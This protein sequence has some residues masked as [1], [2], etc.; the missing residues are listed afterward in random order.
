LTLEIALV[1]ALLV[2]SLVLYSLER[3]PPDVTALGLL[4]ALVLLGLLPASKAFAGFG[5]DTVIM[6]LSLLIMTAALLR[7]G[8][9][10][11]VG[12]ALLRRTGTRPETLLA[13]IMVVVALLS[14]FISNTAAAAF[15]IPVTIGVAQKAGIPQ[16]KLLMPLAFAAILTSS[17]S[18]IS[19]STNLVVNGLMTSRG[20]APMGMFE[21]APVGIPIAIVGLLYVYFIGRRLVPDRGSP[22]ELIE[23]FG[24][25]S[26]LSEVVLLESSPMVGKTIAEAG[27]GHDLDLEILRIR[28][29]KSL[30]LAPRAGTRLLAGDELIVE[31]PREELLKVKDVAGIE[32]KADI[33]LSDPSLRGEEVS[34]VEALLVPGSGLIG[35]TLRGLQF[36]ERYG[37]QVLGLNRHGKNVLRRLSRIKLRVGDV[38]LV[39]GDKGRI[40]LLADQREISVLG[41]VDGQ[42]ID[43]PRALRA[44]IVFGVTLLLASCNVLPLPVAGLLGAFAMFVLRCATP[45]DSYRDVEWRVVI[46]IACMLGFGEAMASTGTAK[47]LA[48]LAADAT[49][50]LAPTWLLGGFFLLTVILTQPMS[51]QAAA[52]VIVPIALEMAAHLGLDPRPFAMMIAVAASCSYLT[53]L[54]PACLLVYGPGRYRFA[55]FFRVGGPLVVLLFLVAL[56]LVPWLWPP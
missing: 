48:Q 2:A 56:L 50:G 18:L 52:A 35:H 1:L 30:E 34:L 27:L 55:D 13:V 17:V 5:S 36:R 31:G 51:N 26:Y 14:A 49:A 38:L 41:A 45:E 32:I 19:T 12:R 24:M 33:E 9:V 22:G 54:E 8:L 11:L 53:P 29:G 37:L 47:Y 39:Q 21:L 7:T 4:L 42:R 20:L 15:F 28:R 10:D 46:M 25:R 43:R 40:A 6:I 16:S 44:A 3:V 23:Q